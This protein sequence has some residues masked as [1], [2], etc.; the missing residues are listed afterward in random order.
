MTQQIY[1]QKN[2]NI[3]IYI[4]ETRATTVFDGIKG[5]M[6]ILINL[7]NPYGP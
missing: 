1:Q 5:A 2:T 7:C 6:Q 3:Y 4:Y